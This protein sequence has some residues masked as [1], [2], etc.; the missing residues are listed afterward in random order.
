MK[1]L[2]AEARA[3]GREAVVYLGRLRH[4]YFLG[5]QIAMLRATRGVTAKGA[6]RERGI[7][8]GEIS[9]I[10]RGM[11]IP[12]EETLAKLGHPLGGRLAYVSEREAVV[13]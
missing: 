3:V 9:R 6:R 10:E 8:R 12:T 13:V 11:C 1:D 4:R 7:D 5:G 2:D